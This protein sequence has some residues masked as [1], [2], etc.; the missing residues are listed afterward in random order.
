MFRER[1]SRADH[2]AKDGSHLQQGDWYIYENNGVDV[3]N[4]CVYEY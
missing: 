1:N 4:D 3:L 2:L